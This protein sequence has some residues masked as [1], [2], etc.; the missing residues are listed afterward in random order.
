MMGVHHF[1]YSQDNKM[2]KKIL[3]SGYM[4]EEYKK[5]S[6][7][8]FP[9]MERY[10][11]KYNIDSA[12]CELENY[13]RPASWSKIPL[14]KNYLNEY[15]VV[16]WIDSDIVIIKDSV[17]IFDYVEN[18][19]IQYMVQHY[20]MDFVVPNAGMWMLKKEML[21]Y[22]DIIWNND[23]YLNHQWWEQASLIELM[24]F[25]IN[26]YTTYLRN[27]TELYHK[28]KLLEQNWNHHP[29]DLKRVSNPFFVHVTTYQD[30]L[31]TIQDIIKNFTL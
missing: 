27:P 23:K 26:E 29:A 28:T 8:T 7:L 22:L 15:D 30:R 31:K 5:M 21:K 2:L 4:G 11:K 25:E 19:K 14:I 18:E 24:G 3:I 10:A 1:L 16:L 9:L 12:I 20:I 13:G 17:N 6:L